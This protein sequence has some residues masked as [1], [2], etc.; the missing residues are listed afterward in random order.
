VNSGRL[1]AHEVNARGGLKLKSG[2]AKIELVRLVLHA[3]LARPL[4]LERNDC[5]AHNFPQPREIM[6]AQ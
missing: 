3:R 1:W 2:P 6:S 4:Q 5:S